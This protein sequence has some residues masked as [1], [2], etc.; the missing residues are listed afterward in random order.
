M[1]SKVFADANLL[2]DFTLQRSNYVAARQVIQHAIHTDI[3]LFTTPSVLHITS[4]YTGRFF[5]GPQTKQIILT[6]LN[7]VQIIDCDHATVL[8]A[9]NSPVA[10]TEDALQYYTALKFGLD[11]FISGDKNLKKVAMPQLPVYTAAELLV[12]LSQP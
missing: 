1:A 12:T 5:T 9:V 11:C 4:Y 6:L 8:I 3:Q 2:L 10:D 7:D